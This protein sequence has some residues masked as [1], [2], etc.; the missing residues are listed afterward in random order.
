M[1]LFLLGATGS[2]GIQTLDIVRNSNDKFRVVSIA[3]NKNISMVKKVRY[4]MNIAKN[5]YES[6]QNLKRTTTKNLYLSLTMF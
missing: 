2:I 4:N 6:I 1:R 3:A 5:T